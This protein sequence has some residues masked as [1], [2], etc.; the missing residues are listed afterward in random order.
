MTLALSERSRRVVKW[1]GYPVCALALFFIFFYLTFPWDKLKYRVEGF[2][3]ASGEMEVTIERLGPAPLFGVSAEQVVV[4]LPPK[5]SHESPPPAAPRGDG[6]PAPEPPPPPRPT[7]VALDRVKV[8]VGLLALLA[9]GVDVKFSVAGFGGEL[10][11]SYSADKKKGWSARATLSKL[12]L[13]RLP[14]VSGTVGLPVAG[15]FSARVEL[16][17]PEDQWA[18]AVGSVELE[19]DG[20]SVG[21]GKAK[22]KVPGNPLLAMGVT[23][24]QLR[25][26][27]LGG[28]IKIEK[29]QATLENVSSQSPDIEVALEGLFNLRTP[30]AYSNAQAY[31]RFRISPELKRRD[32]KF[33]LLENGMVNAKRADGFFGMRVDGPLKGLRF[34]PSSI[35]PAPGGPLRIE[36]GGP[37]PGFR[38]FRPQGRAPVSKPT[39]GRS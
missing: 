16:S 27:R 18:N 30:F 28:K 7:R 1:V 33:E 22:L 38:G 15:A 21:D 35:G 24:P 9:G 36:P 19:C 29:G 23:L 39:S 31:L 6:E 20:C 8:H 14:F 2:L 25:L 34:T 5:P 3:S 10:E 4:T 32:A 13:A 17:V 11:G 37:R 26:G 12:D